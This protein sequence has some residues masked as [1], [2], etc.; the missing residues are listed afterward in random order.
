MPTPNPHRNR[1]PRRR[2]RPV[3]ARR[4]DTAP[5]LPP[6]LAVWISTDHN[7]NDDTAAVPATLLAR[8]I[9]H[10]SA[11]DDLILYSATLAHAAQRAAL[12]RR[13]AL[14]LEPLHAHELATTS[15][16]TT[17]DGRLRL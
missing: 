3:T 16:R 7:D 6:P 14:A 4:T 8:L 12:L 10:Y 11:R 13:R 17:G 2:L 15:Q 9:G 5:S 1:L